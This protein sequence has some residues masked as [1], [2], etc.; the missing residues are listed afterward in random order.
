MDAQTLINCCGGLLGV[1]KGIDTYFCCYGTMQSKKLRRGLVW[2]AMERAWQ[3]W[4]CVTEQ[5]S[6][7][8]IIK[9]SHSLLRTKCYRVLMFFPLLAAWQ[10]SLVHCSYLF[11][12]VRRSCVWGVS[13]SELLISAVSTWGRVWEH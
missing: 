10:V 3:W 8:N 12:L 11:S 4:L 5:L 1:L 2:D 9:A 13:P 6:V 7:L